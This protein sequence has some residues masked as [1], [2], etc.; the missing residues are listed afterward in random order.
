MLYN[1]YVIFLCS[2]EIIIP[3]LSLNQTKAWTVSIVDYS[4]FS[5]LTEL[6]AWKNNDNVSNCTT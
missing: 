6:Y 1:S 3:D 5:E 4:R 2:L